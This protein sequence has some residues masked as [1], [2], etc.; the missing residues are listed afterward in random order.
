M[1]HPPNPQP[2]A[3]LARQ[4]HQRELLGLLLKRL[5][6]VMLL[7]AALKHVMAPE[8]GDLMRHRAGQVALMVA[9][10]PEGGPRKHHRAAGGG[11]PLDIAQCIAL[12]HQL[13]PSIRVALVGIELCEQLALIGLAEAPLLCQVGRIAARTHHES[14][15]L[16]P[17]IVAAA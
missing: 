7:V 4:A 2:A 16:R 1:R 15:G 8:V 11:P 13:N 17:Q 10:G 3:R 9:I 14:D 12:P 5:E 6:D